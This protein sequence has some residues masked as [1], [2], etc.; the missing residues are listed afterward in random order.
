[1]NYLKFSKLS[2]ATPP[3]RTIAN[4]TPIFS[5]FFINLTFRTDS[6]SVACLLFSATPFSYKLF[7]IQN[8]NWNRPGPRA[9]YTK[10]S[11]SE[12]Q[13][14]RLEKLGSKHRNDQPRNSLGTRSRPTG[15]T[16]TLLQRPHTSKHL[17][18]TIL[19]F[20]CSTASCCM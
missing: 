8:E 9:V 18:Y 3:F 19:R 17:L 6:G 14:Y 16:L 7:M 20:C 10:Y 12:I 1:M 2:K 11:S 5:Y 4:L 15:L 13:Q